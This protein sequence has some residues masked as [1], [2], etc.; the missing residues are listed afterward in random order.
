MEPTVPKVTTQERAKKF[1]ARRA[2]RVAAARQVLLTGAPLDRMGDKYD[3]A[4]MAGMTA[5][6]VED[7]CTKGMPHMRFGK[8]RTRFHLGE[9][10][11]WLREQYGERRIGK[12]EET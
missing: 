9:V 6:W 3:V 2:E 5:R 12:A 11:K 7:Q 4:A 10:M 1:A 8:R